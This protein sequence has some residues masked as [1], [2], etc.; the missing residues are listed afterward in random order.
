M[1][2]RVVYWGLLII[3]AFVLIFGT[4][5]VVE[6]S[7]EA[8]FLAL[9]VFFGVIFIDE[10]INIIKL[11]KVMNNLDEDHKYYIKIKPYTTLYIPLMYILLGCTNI[12]RIYDY[13]VMSQLYNNEE[14]NSIINIL[15]S[16]DI[17]DKI[18]LII[19]IGFVVLAII[20]MINNFLYKGIVYEEGIIYKGNKA[21]KYSDIK[22]LTY[23]NAFL[24][25]I[26]KNKIV[27]IK[28]KKLEYT[29]K[30]KDEEF[31]ELV[32]YLENKTN[33]EFTYTG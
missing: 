5:D 7:N 26:D 27:K 29:L 11:K 22:S 19:D 23:R 28:Y 15:I 4:G 21:V 17:N 32:E 30:A 1:M 18:L 3:S 8:K 10:V 31:R 20:L 6:V 33:I 12:Q 13:K 24:N 14:V 9:I 2:S 16:L 25:S